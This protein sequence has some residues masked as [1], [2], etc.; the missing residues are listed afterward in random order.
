PPH[1]LPVN[2]TRAMDWS[3]AWREERAALMRLAA[4]LRALACLAEHAAGRPAIVRGVVLW[5]LR[6]AG[7][8]AGDFLAD[9]MAAGWCLAGVTDRSGSFAAERSASGQFTVEAP[10]P[11]ALAGAGN[12]PEDAMRLAAS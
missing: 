12:R 8:V 10:D 5:L 3:R 1:N 4:L 11:A 2:G 7:A 6:H 9:Q